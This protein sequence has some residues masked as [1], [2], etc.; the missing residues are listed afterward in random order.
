[1][2]AMGE[3]LTSFLWPY[4]RMN[5]INHLKIKEIIDASF[6]MR[7]VFY[8]GPIFADSTVNKSEAG[9]N[10]SRQTNIGSV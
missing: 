5:L 2:C 4:D 9:V 1:M 6:E 3:C 7:P 8:F 10:E